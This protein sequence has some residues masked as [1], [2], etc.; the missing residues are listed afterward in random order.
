MITHKSLDPREFYAQNPAAALQ[1]NWIEPELCNFIISLNM[2]VLRLVTVPRVEE[3]AIGAGSE[4][5][6]HSSASFP[7]L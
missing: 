2:N 3:E 4:Y 7:G 6:G 1:P 5:C